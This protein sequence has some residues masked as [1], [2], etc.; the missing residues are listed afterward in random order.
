MI[1]HVT[2]PG[3]GISLT[4]NRVAFTVFGVPVYWYGICIALGLVLGLVFAF[5]KARSYGINSDR[6]IDVVM[7]AT[8]C[9]I[10]GARAYYVAFAPFEYESLWDMVNLRDGGLAIYGGVLAAF[11]SG[12]LLCRWRRVPTLPMF[13]LAAMG[14]LIGQGIGRWGNFFNQ[15]AFGTNTTLPWG[16]Y[17][18]GTQNY[19]A[20]VQATLAAQ[21]VTV[22]PSLP[23]HPTFLYESLWC[24]LGFLILFLY[25]RHR[26]FHGEIFLLYVIWYGMERFVVE[27]LR[28]DSLETVG[29]VRVS[30]LLA[31]VSV[32]VAGAVWLWQRKKCQ[33]QSLMITYPVVDKRLKGPAV[34]T[35]ELG[36]EPSE[37]ELKAQIEQLV[38]QQQSAESSQEEPAQV[39]C[40]NTTK[41]QQR[42]PHQSRSAVLERRASRQIENIHAE[43]ARSVRSLENER[44]SRRKIRHG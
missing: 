21:G 18:E 43:A 40:A 11:I 14:F 3:L 34:L 5:S 27:G 19:L 28:T 1:N 37:Q 41:A 39:P 2:F 6:M 8:L 10:V 15:E 33:G 13:D 17:S 9:A 22:D 36:K 16:M 25:Q 32:I 12:I 35:W 30:Q 4:I 23:V 7:L 20:T 38:E 29:G 42:K 44:P 24:L 31:L 26:K